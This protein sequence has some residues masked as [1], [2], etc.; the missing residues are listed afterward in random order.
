MFER[1]SIDFADDASDFGDVGNFFEQMVAKPHSVQ[2][3]VSNLGTSEQEEV[4]E[5]NRCASAPQLSETSLSWPSRLVVSVGHFRF[6]HICPDS[7]ISV[8]YESSCHKIMRGRPLF[9]ISSGD[10][11][12]SR[13]TVLGLSSATRGPRSGALVPCDEISEV[14]RDVYYTVV[15]RAPP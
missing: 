9:K 4:M 5:S 15:V 11:Q 14:G 3:F 13:R 6:V 8:R 10:A 7:S 1:A 2:W 12:S